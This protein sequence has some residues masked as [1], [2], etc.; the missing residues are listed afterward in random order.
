VG[1][2]QYYVAA[3]IDG[4]IA[5]HDGGLDWL[6][7]IPVGRGGYDEFYAG[8][9]ALVMG[10]GTYEWVLERVEK[11][12]YPEGP[13]W[14]FTHRELKPF[15]DGDI[16]FVQGSPSEHLDE[17]REAAGDKNIWVVGG[18][19]LASQFVEEGLL[20]ELILNVASA[21]LG[22]GIPLFA[23]RIPGHLHLTATQVKGPGMVELRYE[24]PTGDS[25]G[26][27]A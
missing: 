23:G 14:V 20:D 7:S 17:M 1:R 10:A 27:E 25:A 15:E 5:E 4:F 2:T 11:W 22:E 19:E 6:T 8:V 26:K 24:F 18:G 21:V 13:T 12:P 16:R 9:G 3:T